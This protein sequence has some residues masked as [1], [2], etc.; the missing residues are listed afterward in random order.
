MPN[1]SRVDLMGHLGRDAELKQVG[2]YTVLKWSMAVTHKVKGEKVTTW[3]SCDLFGKR[4]E[5]LAP[6][7]T[8]GAA[9]FVSGQLKP[10]EYK[11]KQDELRI[12]LDVDVR[13]VELLGGGAGAERDKAPRNA[14]APVP[15]AAGYDDETPF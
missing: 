14:P 5:S 4:A 15:S 1:L 11:G 12:S 9:V 7:L 2:D 8:K 10:R 6:Y 3:Y 13:E